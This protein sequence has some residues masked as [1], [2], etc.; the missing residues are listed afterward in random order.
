MSSSLS[1]TTTSISSLLYPALVSSLIE[2]CITHPIDVIKIHKQ[3]NMPLTYNFKTL[4]KGF[5]PRAIGNIPSRTVFLFTQDYLQNCIIR[6]N[7]D[8]TNFNNN[9]NNKNNQNNKNNK[10]N[11]HNKINKITQA[12]IIPF[13]S[14]FAQTLVDTPVEV[15]KM[16]KIMSMNNKNP[17]KGF[18]PHFGRNLIFVFFVYNFKQFG[19]GG[20]CGNE[21]LKNEKGNSCNGIVTCNNNSYLQTAFY[22]AIGGLLGSYFSHPLDTIK[23]CVQTNRN[24]DYFKAK[25]YMRGGHLRAGMSMIN[26]FISLYVFERMKNL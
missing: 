20:Y 19:G 24:Y 8:E 10:H 17:Y 23:T 12:L 21:V 5:C 16:N 3:T 2:N 26:I 4:Y 22:G 6:F 15:L 11:K 1:L 25:E 14:G 7:N 9:K 18:L 13:Y